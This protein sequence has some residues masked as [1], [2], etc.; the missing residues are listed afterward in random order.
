MEE[1]ASDICDIFNL[2]DLS[3]LSSFNKN[4]HIAAC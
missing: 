1:I 4:S 3:G 2:K